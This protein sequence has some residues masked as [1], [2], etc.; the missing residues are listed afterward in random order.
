MDDHFRF[1]SKKNHAGILAKSYENF[2]SPTPWRFKLLKK[3]P[4]NCWGTDPV[5]EVFLLVHPPPPPK[6]PIWIGIQNPYSAGNSFLVETI[7]RKTTRFQFF[8]AHPEPW[9]IFDP[10]FWLEGIFWS[11]GFREKPPTKTRKQP[12]EANSGGILSIDSSVFRL[13]QRSPNRPVPSSERKNTGELA[14]NPDTVVSKERCF[15]PSKLK[16]GERVKENLQPRC[17]CALPKCFVFDSETLLLCT[18]RMTAT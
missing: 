14:G 6:T 18:Q 8:F 3:T 13:R 4:P 5:V 11:K 10:I 15:F 17:L 16:W 7:L 12:W 9:G 1:F 2:L